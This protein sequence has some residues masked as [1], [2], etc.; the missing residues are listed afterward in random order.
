MRSSD[1]TC[2]FSTL[3]YLSNLAH[4]HKLPAIITFDQPLFWKA[5]EILN[6]LNDDNDLKN[7]VLMLGSF[8][9]LMNLLG[10]IGTLMDGAG[11]RE[12]LQVIY[13][14]NT[15]EHMLHG[16]AV[17]R[18]LRGFLTFDKCLT[19]YLVRLISV[20]DE[21]FG[22]TIDTLNQKYESIN[23]ETVESLTEDETFMRVLEVMN[24]KKNKLLLSPRRVNYGLV[25]NI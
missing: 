24:S 20:D 12:V 21:Q 13:G 19:Q 14:E 25:F 9:T 6:D 5:S 3:S 11:L 15:V 23:R 8:H 16:R 1:K 10:A 7:I 18:A 17:Q 22:Q 2:I 4:N